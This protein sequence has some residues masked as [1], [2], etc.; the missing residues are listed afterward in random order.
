VLGTWGRSGGLTRDLP[1]PPGALLGDVAGPQG[2]PSSDTSRAGPCPGARRASGR[3]RTSTPAWRSA[4]RAAKQR[5]CARNCLLDRPLPHLLEH[6][7]LAWRNAWLGRRCE[8]RD[9]VRLARGWLDGWRVTTYVLGDK[10]CE[11]RDDAADARWEEDTRPVGGHSPEFGR[12]R[13]AHLS[14]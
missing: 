13:T 10:T 2:S 5:A 14:R 1:A 7:G 9:G 8:Y 11:Q 12:S 6:R 3:Q 4:R